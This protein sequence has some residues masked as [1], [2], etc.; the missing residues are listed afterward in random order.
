MNRTTFDEATIKDNFA[1]AQV[2]LYLFAILQVV[3][4]LMTATG[5][6]PLGIAPQASTMQRIS[7]TANAVVNILCFTV[8]YVLLARCLNRCT[9]LVWRIAFSLFL[10]N[11]GV[12]VLA[13]A[14]QPNL[15]PVLTCGLSVAGAISV[16][17]G[18][19]AVRDYAVSRS[20]D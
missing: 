4:S 3:I 12:A 8:G 9:T 16:W 15:Y 2:A 7:T 5:A 17:N 10:L 14:A 1:V 19:G 6:V 11:T 18:R 20:S 13:I